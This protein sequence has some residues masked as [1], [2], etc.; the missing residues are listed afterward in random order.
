[1]WKNGGSHPDAVW[2]HKSDGSR[3]EADTGVLGPIGSWEGVLLGPNLGCAIV[4][5]GDFMAYVCNSA[6]TRPS[7]QITL[8]KLVIITSSLFVMRIVAYHTGHDTIICSTAIFSKLVFTA[9][10]YSAVTIECIDAVLSSQSRRLILVCCETTSCRW[11]L[12]RVRNVVHEYR[13]YRDCTD[14]SAST[15]IALLYTR[16]SVRNLVY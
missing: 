4:T 11:P 10:L 8:S 5:N 14:V 6:A 1:M 9:R 2:H 7:P 16:S 15:L 12:E 13:M 3:D